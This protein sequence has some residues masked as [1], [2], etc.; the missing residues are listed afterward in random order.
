MLVSLYM[1]A[2]IFLLWQWRLCHVSP[3]AKLA[4]SGKPKRI[5]PKYSE[6]NQKQQLQQR[7]FRTLSE[8]DRRI[9]KTFEN[10]F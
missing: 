7:T 4:R 8:N 5:L 9:V 2:P 3:E 1:I 6:N 10:D